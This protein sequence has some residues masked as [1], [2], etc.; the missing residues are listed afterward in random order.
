MS[1]GLYDVCLVNTKKPDGAIRLGTRAPKDNKMSIHIFDKDNKLIDT[2][3]IK[4][5]YRT[6]RRIYKGFREAYR[7]SLENIRK[8]EE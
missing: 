2:V 8:E 6:V 4:L 5:S 1:S 7:I 3:D